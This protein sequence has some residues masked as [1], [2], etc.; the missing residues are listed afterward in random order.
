MTPAPRLHSRP[1]ACPRALALAAWLLTAGLGLPLAAQTTPPP[2]DA[3]TPS[4]FSGEERVTAVEVLVE[5]EK[6]RTQ[7]LKAGAKE[8]LSAGDFEIQVDGRQTTVT[9]LRTFST[10]EAEPWRLV[11]YFDTALTSSRGLTWA[12][13]ALTEEAATLTRLGTVE[14]VIAD[15]T[16]RLLLPP[17][18]DAELLGATLGQLAVSAQGLDQLV[19]ARA[20]FLRRTSGAAVGAEADGSA[21]DTGEGESL[22]DDADLRQRVVAA[23]QVAVER[24]QD[25]L[26]LRLSGTEGGPRRALI[27]VSGGWDV[28]PAAF[29]GLR[30]G[31]PMPDDIEEPVLGESSGELARSLAAYGWVVIDLLRP[32]VPPEKYFPRGKRVGKWRMTGVHWFY[33][34]QRDPKKAEALIQLGDARRTEGNLEEAAESYRQAIHY[35]YKDPRTAKRQA[36]AFAGLADTL[37]SMGKEEESRWARQQAA[38]LDP[39]QGAG[40]PNAG[41]ILLDPAAPLEALADATAGAIVQSPAA[42]SDALASLD[43]RVGLSFQLEGPPLGRLL[44]IE[45]SI[46]SLGLDLRAPGW[47]RSSTPEGVS[48]ARARRLVE[49]EETT[50]DER[51]D[52]KTSVRFQP[53]PSATTGSVEADLSSLVQSP[54][55]TPPNSLLVRVTLALGGPDLAPEVRHDLLELRRSPT[56]DQ[57]RWSLPITLPTGVDRIAVVIEDLGT[58]RWSGETLEL[59]D[60]VGVQEAQ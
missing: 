27:L 18:R 45:V 41:A 56:P 47:V 52:L 6:R 15:P 14:V 1:R 59:G 16:P 8:E 7:D 53:G 9:G 58:G 13:T 20:E 25:Q 57:R 54:E 40:Q 42:L 30:S 5:V 29:Y 3:Q 32:E 23:E 51:A 11:I 17:T 38:A 55:G 2:A 46:F 44:P 37:A 12:A 21:E 26:L 22:T 19:E 31:D 43:H 4:T 28:D 35:F 33:E 49:G 48:A 36:L 60:P 24:Q 10:A 50:P 34:D 39:A